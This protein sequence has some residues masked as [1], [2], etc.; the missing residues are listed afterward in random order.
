MVRLIEDIEV[1]K[2]KLTTTL[3]LNPILL[4]NLTKDS[5]KP[6]MVNQTQS[7]IVPNNLSQLVTSLSTLVPAH[8]ETTQLITYALIAT[9]LVGI[10]VY[11]YIKQQENI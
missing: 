9:A 11:H 1:M 10:F 7:L 8:S 2:K 3:P 4:L 6:M 5:K